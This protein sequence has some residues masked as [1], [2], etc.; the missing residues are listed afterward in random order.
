[1][2]ML[3]ASMWSSCLWPTLVSTGSGSPPCSQALSSP[4]QGLPRHT[5]SPST[6]GVSVLCARMPSCPCQWREEKRI[7]FQ[8]PL[9]IILPYLGPLVSKPTSVCSS[10]CYNKTD[11]IMLYIPAYMFAASTQR[12]SQSEN[13]P[14]NLFIPRT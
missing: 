7:I 12:T 14:L 3:G 6:H 9:E 5:L 11:P 13:V 10:P 4:S 8:E 2:S 1:M